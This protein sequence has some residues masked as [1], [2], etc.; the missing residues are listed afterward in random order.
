MSKLVEIDKEMNT[1]IV[2]SL[3]HNDVPMWL[4]GANVNFTRDSITPLIP[5]RALFQKQEAM[6]I[7]GMIEAI[8]GGEPHVFFGT[9]SKLWRWRRSDGLVDVSRTTGG[10][11][12]G[13]LNSTASVN[14]TEWHFSQWGQ[15]ITAT[16]GVDVPQIYKPS[17]GTFAALPTENAGGLTF[18]YAELMLPFKSFMFALNTMNTHATPVGGG[19]DIINFSELDDPEHWDPT[20]AGNVYAN[21]LPVR[22]AAGPLIAA[23]VHYENLM[24][25]TPHSM[26]TVSFVGAPNFFGQVKILDECGCYGKHALATHNRIIYGMGLMGIWRTDGVTVQNFADPVIQKYVMDNFN[27]EQKCK[28]V[29]WNNVFENMMEFHYPSLN[30][31]ENS[32]AIGFNYL[33]NAWTIIERARSAATRNTTFSY[34]VT[35]S[36]TG[37]ILFQ[38]TGE[39]VGTSGGFDA[40]GALFGKSALTGGT[41]YGMGGYGLGGYGGGFV[42]R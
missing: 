11:Y 27:L 22:D 25:F 10:P 7:R 41:G 14:A 4:A 18:T 16:N 24:V 26:H 39:L 20:A 19:R 1:G 2:P 8:I 12:S 40:K 9:L 34:G 36:R 32:R 38:L 5:H 42:I 15:W 3:N 28:V 31:Q 30:S 29:V 23:L 37:D 13:I 6:P 21:D 33:S 17:V 35:G